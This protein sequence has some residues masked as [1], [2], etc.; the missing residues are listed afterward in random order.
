MLEATRVD[1]CSLNEIGAG[2]FSIPSNN[3]YNSPPMIQE[4]ND[5]MPQP[6]IIEERMQWSGEKIKNHQDYRSMRNFD[7]VATKG[8]KP[9]AAP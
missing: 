5:T 8:L 7:S 6:Y 9:Y 4:R 1:S 3:M 2:L